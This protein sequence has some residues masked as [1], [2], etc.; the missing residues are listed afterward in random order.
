VSAS[1]PPRGPDSTD[2]LQSLCLR[3]AS[4]VDTRDR[5]MLLGVF[6]PDALVRVFEPPGDGVAAARVM[7]GHDEIGE[8][9]RRIA[10]Y[11]RTSHLVGAGSFRVEGDGATGVVHCTAHHVEGRVDQV[12]RVRYDDRYGRDAG[13]EWRIRARDVR[14]LSRDDRPVPLPGHSGD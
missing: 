13:G 9:V 7:R 4:A 10:V 5:G 2:A 8:I 1:D 11:E 12:M 6:A 3:Y 14:I